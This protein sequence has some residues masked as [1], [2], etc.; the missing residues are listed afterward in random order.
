MK[1]LKFGGTSLGGADRIR[2]VA[3]ILEEERE[4]AIVVLS[5]I[6]ATTDELDAFRVELRDGERARARERIDALEGWYGHLIASLFGE[7]EKEGVK[8]L[9][10]HMEHLRNYTRTMITVHEER[11]ILAQGELLSTA[12]LHLYL[13]RS[14]MRVDLLPALD[15]MWVDQEREPDRSYIAERLEKVLTEK[16]RSGVLLTQGYICRDPF[17][18]VDNLKR[19]GSDLTA[20][21]IAASI[22]A[23]ELCIW[24]D[25]DGVQNNDPRVVEDARPVRRMSFDEAAELSYFGAKVL[26]PSSVRPAKESGIPVRLKN[27]FD[28]GS[29]GTLVQDEEAGRVAIRAIAAKDGI[30]AVRVRSG[31]MLM[32]YGFL[33][34]VFE[35]FELYRTPIDMITTSE[36]AVSLTIDDESRLDPIL[37]ELRAFG[38]V[39]VDREQSIICIVGD[40]VYERTG[41]ARRIFNALGDIPVRMIAY[42]GS[43]NNLSLLVDS[44]RKQEA[45]LALHKGVFGK[46]NADVDEA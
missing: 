34:R 17:G 24:T 26:H 3:S 14:G 19:G 43:R 25:V 23:E 21:L 20:S 16:D 18:N 10:G 5:A 41:T 28:P 44:D 30:T 9:K 46:S 31:R 27:S 35:V 15:V 38:T 37:E 45:L 8:L 7:G 39:E 22:G 12:I 42:G 2:R 36:V 4:G 32:A 13:Q 40:M 33:K 29:E 1:V 6:G 11:E